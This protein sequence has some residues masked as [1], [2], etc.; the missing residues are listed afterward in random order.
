M[1][2]AALDI[3]GTAIKSGIWD[4]EELTVLQERETGASR[5]AER[6]MER[7]VEILRGCGPFDAVGVSTAGQVDTARGSIHYANGNM[8]GYT[9]MKVR[10]ILEREFGV[11]V[12]VENDVNAAALGEMYRGAARGLD[13]F[14]CLT[15]GTG[16]GG[17]IVMDGK[18]WAG[19]NWAGGSFGGI[20]VH[21]EQWIAG[22]EWSGCYEKYASVTALVGKARQIDPALDD[23]RRIFAAMERQEVR[24][25]VDQW[26]DE[27]VYGLVTLIHIFN[28]GHILLGGGILAQPYVLEEIRRRV[29][30]RLMPETRTVEIQRTALGNR[31]GLVG[32]S[33]LAGQLLEGQA[34]K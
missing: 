8:P 13:S 25:A 27:I 7:V 31:A 32:A 1:R 9:G 28:P 14:L 33:V 2:I 24:E 16:V 21:P 10:E 4:G 11:P 26:I 30:P 3:G 23:G 6:V 5:G 17:A 34:W 15:Y 20:M 22:E 29:M 18:I 12:A 19:S